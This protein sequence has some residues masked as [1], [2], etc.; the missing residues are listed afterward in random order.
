MTL[1]HLIKMIWTVV[2][3]LFL[4][5]CFRSWYEKARIPHKFPPGPYGLP[6]LGYFPILTKGF[7]EAIQDLNKRFGGIYSV[8][9]GPNK[10]VVVI[11]D[12]EILKDLISV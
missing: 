6:V 3:I 5:W 4:I 10:R 12:Y 2:L 7:F 9:L 11:G 8:N 1:L